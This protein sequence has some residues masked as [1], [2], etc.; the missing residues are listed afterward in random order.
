MSL[1]WLEA[2]G[3]EKARLSCVYVRDWDEIRCWL[4]RPPFLYIPKPHGTSLAGIEENPHMYGPV[5]ILSKR[6]WN[7]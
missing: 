3:L 7:S 6:L 1:T 5:L 2:K 4:A